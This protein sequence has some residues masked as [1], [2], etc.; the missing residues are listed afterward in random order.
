MNSK[1]W[2][3]KTLLSHFLIPDALEFLSFFTFKGPLAELFLCM[4]KAS[5]SLLVFSLRPAVIWEQ[6]LYQIL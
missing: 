1:I 2:S 5:W 4:S 6:F 3:K